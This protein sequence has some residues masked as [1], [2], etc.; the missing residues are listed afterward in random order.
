M[1]IVL[2]NCK[3]IPIYLQIVQEI[4]SDILNGE[5]KSDESLPSIRQLALDLKVSVITVKNA[6]DELEK[7]GFIYALPS[8]GF[9][10]ASFTESQIKKMRETIAKNVI[11]KQINYLQ[12]IGLDKED[13]LKIINEKKN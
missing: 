13:I 9:F 1:K 8:K 3:D 12:S 7:D 11:E 2:S 6:Y 10:V 5:L 4:K